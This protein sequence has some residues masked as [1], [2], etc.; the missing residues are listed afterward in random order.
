MNFQARLAANILN[1]GGV[2][3]NPTD[4][5]QG[6]TCLPNETSLQKMLQL[7][8]RSP[9][10]GLILLASEVRFFQPFVQDVDLLAQIMP[11]KQ[12]TTYLLK[13]HEDVSAL[14]T[15]DFDA[16]AVRLTDNRLIASLCEGCNSALLSTSANITGRNVATSTL[17]L[18]VAFKQELDF[19][20][21]PQNY[22]TQAS[23]IIN[24]Q[25]GE[26]LR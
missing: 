4:T 12:P 7:K 26:R 6:L 24:L 16:V 9:K 23:Q 15:G 5:I 10:K 20:I 19:I 3:S 2:I 13:A 1:L 17:E 11:Q 14:I 21:A 25:T 18:N 8:R 22:N